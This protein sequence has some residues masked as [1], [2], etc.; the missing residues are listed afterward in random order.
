MGHTGHAFEQHV[1]VGHERGEEQMHG[2][3]L[4]HHIVGHMGA[5]RGDA[6]G[7]SGEI[8]AIV[9]GHKRSGVRLRLKNGEQ[10]LR[11]VRVFLELRA[12][13][14][15][16]SVFGVE[17]SVELCE[18][19]GE[20]VVWKEAAGVSLRDFAAHSRPDSR[21]ARID[22]RFA[23]GRAAS[24]AR[25]AREECSCA[26]FEQ[27]AELSGEGQRRIAHARQVALGAEAAARVEEQCQNGHAD[28]NPQRQTQRRPLDEE[29]EPGC[30]SHLLAHRRPYFCK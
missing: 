24:A 16:H 3:G 25:F 12:S 18:L 17:Q 28:R 11:E 21:A 5:E 29:G 13:H 15:G 7:E 8:E 6:F 9:V 30:C 1:A 20:I 22:I 26:C 27:C 14:E 10:E 19:L 2:Q 4:S 23:G